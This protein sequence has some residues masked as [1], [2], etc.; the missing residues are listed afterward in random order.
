MPPFPELLKQT[1]KILSSQ[2]GT[3]S[4][5]VLGTV[6]PLPFI[7]SEDTAVVGGAT[8]AELRRGNGDFFAREDGAGSLPQG[9]PHG[10]KLF[11]AYQTAGLA[12]THTQLGHSSDSFPNTP[13]DKLHVSTHICYLQ[14]QAVWVPWGFLGASLAPSIFKYLANQIFQMKREINPSQQLQRSALSTDS[15]HFAASKKDSP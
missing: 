12:K 11:P 2:R 5:R 3:S 1:S 13:L 15:K 6:H 4:T 14:I 9:A 8:E 7:S 10:V